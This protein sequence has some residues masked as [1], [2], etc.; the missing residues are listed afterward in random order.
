MERY[1]FLIS[2]TGKIFCIG[3]DY[4]WREFW[5]DLKDQDVAQC[6]IRKYW[7]PPDR[8]LSMLLTFSNPDYKD[9]I[10]KLVKYESAEGTIDKYENTIN[11]LSIEQRV[12]DEN[13]K[14]QKDIGGEP[15]RWTNILRSH[16][17]F[18]INGN[19]ISSMVSKEVY[20]V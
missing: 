3:T 12:N 16:V 11:G 6:K 17:P 8:M 2:N 9:I 5:Y 13:S 4:H 20:N 1:D 10:Q 18:V 15:K 14:V 7:H 19:I